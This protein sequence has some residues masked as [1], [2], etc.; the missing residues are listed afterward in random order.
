[1]K[2][3]VTPNRG[4]KVHNPATGKPLPAEGCEV[5]WNTWWIR[6]ERHGEVT[7]GKPKP[8]AKKVTSKSTDRKPASPDEV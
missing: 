3:H 1:M 2:K 8:K 7:V 4:L 6:R 5:E